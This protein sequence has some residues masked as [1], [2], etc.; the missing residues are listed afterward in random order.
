MRRWLDDSKDGCIYFSF[1]SMTRIET[2]PKHVLDV[3]YKSFEAL[4]PARVVWKIVK[5]EILP[6]GLPSNVLT[7]SWL[8]Q[9]EILSSYPIYQQ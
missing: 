3:F 1:G 8:Q 5:P 9:N 4:K 2:F 6:P 7:K